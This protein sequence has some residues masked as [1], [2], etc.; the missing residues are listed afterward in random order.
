MNTIATIIR[1][2]FSFLIAM[3][4][5]SCSKDE[6]KVAHSISFN[7]TDITLFCGFY[8]DVQVL[9]ET[10]NISNCTV[11]V[12]DENIAYAEKQGDKW[13]IITRWPGVTEIIAT[14]KKDKNVIATIPLRVNGPDNIMFKIE[15][16]NLTFNSTADEIKNL[17]LKTYTILGNF[18]CL[19]GAY[20]YFVSI[21]NSNPDVIEIDKYSDAWWPEEVFPSYWSVYY[22]PGNYEAQYSYINVPIKPL[23]SG[24]SIITAK[25]INSTNNREVKCNVTV[26]QIA[27]KYISLPASQLTLNLNIQYKLIAKVVPEDADNVELEWSSSDPKIATVDQTGLITTH[28]T[29][30]TSIIVKCKYWGIESSCSVRVSKW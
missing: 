30:L 28:S 13:S 6:E 16:N 26:D 27:A 3:A 7:T 1:C 20:P 24:S 22:Q 19:N 14:S 23:R 15:P 8:K 11:Y 4:I 29:G 18:T 21:S 9:D 17:T 10:G 2:I 12:K 25:F 5:I